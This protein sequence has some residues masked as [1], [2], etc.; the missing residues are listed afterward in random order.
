MKPER[1][2]SH[3]CGFRAALN[4][5]ATVGHR[6]RT[7]NSRLIRVFFKRRDSLMKEYINGETAR[8]SGSRGNRGG[9]GSPK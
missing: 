2:N 7:R 5:S 4:A 1:V 6:R 9:R 8:F 3:W